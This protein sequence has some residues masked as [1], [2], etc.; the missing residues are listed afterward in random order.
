MF[1]KIY[2]KYVTQETISYLIF[3]ILTTLVDWVIHTI[4][5]RC[6][7]EYWI[8]TMV[9][10]SGA[11]LF[12]FITN[13]QFVFQSKANDAATIWKEFSAF[14]A[15]RAFTGLFTLVGMVIMVQ[16]LHLHEMIGK[17]I[18]SAAS[19]VLNYVFSKLLIFN[20]KPEG[21]EL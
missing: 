5:W 14:V 9:S 8:S 7:V 10:W 3:G 17:L 4:M 18:V 6:G 16:G 15:C 1:R 21:E 20:K 13:R 11:V 12:A 19:L 2:D